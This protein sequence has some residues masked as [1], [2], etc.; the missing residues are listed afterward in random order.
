[1]AFFPEHVAAMNRALGGMMIGLLL[2]G[3]SACSLFSPREKKDDKKDNIPAT[4][5]VGRIASV[6]ADR[7]FV[8]I[9]SY[10]PWE[11]A[12]GSI[13]T[14]QGPDQRLA[15][16]KCSGEK[17]G[18]FA[19]ADIQAGLPQTGDAVFSSLELPSM[20]G[21]RSPIARP[22]GFTPSLNSGSPCSP[23]LPQVP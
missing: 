4:K 8:M 6:S 22:E 20:T 17:L 13:L 21:G 16:L 12:A 7:K 15:N 14:T 23:Q 3:L 11:I 10:G 1:V 18:Q 19:A 2:S 5:L 9:Q